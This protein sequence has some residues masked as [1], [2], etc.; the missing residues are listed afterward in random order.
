MFR[1]L[2]RLPPVTDAEEEALYS[3]RLPFR[4]FESP[5]E[6][7]F[8]GGASV[9]PPCN[10]PAPPACERYLLAPGSPRQGA[11]MPNHLAPLQV[12]PGLRAYPFLAQVCRHWKRVLESPAALQALWGELCI[13]FG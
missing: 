6:V 2:A 12:H 8:A 9:V 10:P 3:R 11:K 4:T 5:G 1:Q 13:D 7:R